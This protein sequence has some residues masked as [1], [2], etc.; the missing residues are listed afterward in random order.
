M[1]YQRFDA[2]AYGFPKPRVSILPS[3][4]WES[5]GSQSGGLFQPLAQVAT[6]QY[7]SRGR[8]AL[9]EA[10]RL[11]GVSEGGALLAPSYHC[12][13]MLDPAVRLGARISLYALHSDLSPDMTS[14]RSVIQT[15]PVP[16]KALL[17]THY[18]GFAQ[19]LQL[20]TQFCKQHGLALIEDCSHALFVRS[21][22]DGDIGTNG[23]FGIA[24]PYKFFPC[25]DG[26]LLWMNGQAALSLNPLTKPSLKAEIRGVKRALQ[27]LFSRPRTPDTNALSREI[28]TLPA[29]SAFN[30]TDK[31]EDDA[32][33]SDAY[34]SSEEGMAGLSVSQWVIQYTNVDRLAARRRKNYQVWLRAIDGLA[35]CRPLYPELAGGTVPY[36][37]PLI[38]EEPDIHFFALKHLGVPIWRWDDMA[39]SACPVASRYRLRLLHLPCHQE[40]SDPQLAWMTTA[41]RSVLQRSAARHP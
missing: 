1:R 21:D 6:A 7:F 4:C 39:L 29:P 10:Y 14:L 11:A 9:H 40:L 19:H 16:V 22:S 18:F 5:L 30:G 33:T 8:Y 2:E 25:E 27:C 15:S 3:L 20:L 38:L 41:L 36:M 34:A 24:S 23:Q 13:T 26:G 31:D 12:R 32:G 37:F 17:V 35:G 28:E